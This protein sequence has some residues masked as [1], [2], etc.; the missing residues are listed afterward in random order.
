MPS[1]GNSQIFEASEIIELR[2]EYRGEY[3]NAIL[4]N[5]HNSHLYSK[6]ISLFLQMSLAFITHQRNFFL[7]PMKTII[8]N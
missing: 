6:Y 2:G 3:T 7:Q 8:E 4:L 5:Q 1:T